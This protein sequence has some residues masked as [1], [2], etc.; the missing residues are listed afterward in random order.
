MQNITAG[1][2]SS[3]INWSGSAVIKVAQRSNGAT[4]K[5]AIAAIKKDCEAA[6]Q[7]HQDEQEAAHAPLEECG[8]LS[9]WSVDSYYNVLISKYG[10]IDAIVTAMRVFPTHA[11]LQAYG[12]QTLKNMSNILAVQQA[13]GVTA[14]ANAMGLH[15]Q[16]IHVQSE[17]CEALQNHS[18]VLVQEPIDVLR[19]LLP[20]LEH[21]KD[22]YLT[23]KGRTSA[24]FM[25][26]FVRATV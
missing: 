23:P 8:M 20:L 6:Q 18:S 21:A 16:S 19:S 12:C 24:R 17:A 4:V 3:S 7:Q 9:L 11:E 14:L 13:G 5:L 1:N 10:G 15:P 2:G 22:M 25:M 26:D